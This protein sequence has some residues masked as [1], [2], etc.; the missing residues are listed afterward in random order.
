[1]LH[2]QTHFPAIAIFCFVFKLKLEAIQMNELKTFKVRF[3]LLIFS[4]KRG[5]Y[6]FFFFFPDALQLHR[7][8]YN[9]SYE[10]LNELTSDDDIAVKRRPV[11][12]F[13]DRKTPKYQALKSHK[14]SN[15]SKKILLNVSKFVV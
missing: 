8:S 3:I 4:Q 7:L 15:S 2:Q 10:D 13:I 1:V 5:V 6:S 11:S 14:S 12:L 9:V